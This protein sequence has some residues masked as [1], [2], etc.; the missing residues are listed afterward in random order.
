LSGFE[1]PPSPAERKRR[2]ARRRS[3]RIFAASLAVLFAIGIGAVLAVLSRV[4]LDPQTLCPKDAP[5]ASQ[6]AV[7]LDVTD[8]FNPVQRA[9]VQH[10]FERLQSSLPEGAQL[11]L[12]PLRAPARPR[13]EPAMVLCNPGSGQHASHLW[14]NPKKLRRR[15]EAAFR[16]PL[17]SL[18]D[19]ALR[20]PPARTSPIMEQLQALSASAFGYE[21]GSAPRE[22]V[23]IS[24]LLQNSAALSLYRAP[25]DFPRFHG[26]TAFERVRCALPGVSVRI[27]YILR[28]GNP[29]LKRKRSLIRF[30]EQYLDAC[31]AHIESVDVVPGLE[32]FDEP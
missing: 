15:W 25:L 2:A 11:A 9:Y 6:V 5:P 29:Y 26:S 20:A 13:L 24:D 19:E 7:L 16:Q 18:F 32:G 27:L 28:A 14:Q 23:I 30:W 17:A 4:A 8:R 12:Y 3:V 21:D 22:L 1:L 31:G 10:A